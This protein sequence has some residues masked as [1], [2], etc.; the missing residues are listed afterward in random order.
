MMYR[1]LCLV[2]LVVCFVA[3]IAQA[4]IVDVERRPQPTIV[5]NLQVGSPIYFDRTPVTNAPLGHVYVQVPDLLLGADYVMV[6]NNDKSTPGYEL[7]VTVNEACTLLLLIDNRV[8]DNDKATPPTLTTF[9]TW[10]GTLG[11]VDTNVDIGIDEN[12]N[13]SPF[14]SA[15]NWYSIFA[16]QVPAGSTTTLGAA[17]GTG[18]NNPTGYN[19]YTVAIPEP[20]TVALLGLGALTL[21]RRRK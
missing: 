2:A 14:G 10:V 18:T 8:G 11:F 7:D 3:G 21:L 12:G 17:Y 6:A 13:N 19:M 16:K 4:G 9:M 15:D 1:K 20:A 5:S